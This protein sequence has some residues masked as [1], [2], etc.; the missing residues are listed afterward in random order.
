MIYKHQL[1]ATLSP[2]EAS[3]FQIVGPRVEDEPS[4]TQLPLG[5]Q[6]LI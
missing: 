6:L 4:K 3:Y 1:H 2:S 5:W